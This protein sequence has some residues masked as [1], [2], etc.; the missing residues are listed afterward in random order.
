MIDASVGSRLGPTFRQ[1]CDEASKREGTATS[2]SRTTNFLFLVA[3]AAAGAFPTVVRPYNCRILQ[4]SFRKWGAGRGSLF[5]LMTDDA[6]IVIPGIAPHCGS[7][8]KGVF[9]RE[10]ATPFMARFGKPP[11]PLPRRIWA[12]GEDVAVLADA[13]GMRRDGKPYSNRYVF[14]LQMRS[15]RIVKATEFLDMAAFNDV[16]DNVEPA[17]ATPEVR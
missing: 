5:D 12:Q 13:A 10:I 15:G 16:W 6:E 2:V 4:D 11:V 1:R 8:S 3:G 14:V 9:V 7:F 17:S